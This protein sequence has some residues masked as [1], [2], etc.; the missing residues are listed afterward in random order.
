MA[1]DIANAT[2]NEIAGF[3]PV[4]RTGSDPGSMLQLQ[5]R[6][7]MVRSRLLI[8]AVIA[9]ATGTFCWLLLAHLH[10]GAADFTWSMHAAQSLV[11]GKNP[12]D[13]WKEQ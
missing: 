7:L 5:P 6:A 11:A 4:A 8:S 10:Q 1:A 3:I 13:T 9:V 12:Y 2:A